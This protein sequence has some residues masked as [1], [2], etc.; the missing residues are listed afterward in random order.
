[1]TTFGGN[2]NP[3]FSGDDGPATNA[4]LFYPWALSEESSGNF[5]AADTSN[6]R[7]REINAFAAVGRSTSGVAFSGSTV[8]GATD[9][10]IDL[11][12]RLG[13]LPSMA[14]VSAGTSRKPMTASAAC[15]MGQ[16]VPS[17][18]ISLQLALANAPVLLR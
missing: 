4:E 17:R 7:I 18:S 11:T 12:L 15:P 1:M 6:N 10:P 13:P 14:S 5:V 9:G 2:G 8:I 16:H 3:G